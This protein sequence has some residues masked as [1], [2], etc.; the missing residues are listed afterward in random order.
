MNVFGLMNDPS[1]PEVPKRALVQ[2]K[3]SCTLLP[4]GHLPMWPSHTPQG[5]YCSKCWKWNGED[6][7]KCKRWDCGAHRG[8]LW[9]SSG[10]VPEDQEGKPQKGKGDGPTTGSKGKGTGSRRASTWACAGCGCKGNYLTRATCRNC[11]KPWE[12]D[13]PNNFWDEVRAQAS[14]PWSRR[15]GQQLLL[16]R[17]VAEDNQL[18]Q[19]MAEIQPPAAKHKKAKKEHDAAVAIL[20]ELWE[21]A[22]AMEILPATKRQEIA[23][24]DAAVAVLRRAVEAAEA[25]SSPTET[26]RSSSSSPPPTSP[27]D[28]A[29]AGHWTHKQVRST[30]AGVARTAYDQVL[31]Q[32]AVQ[33]Q[34]QQPGGTP[35]KLHTARDAW[36]QHKAAT[37]ST[38]AISGVVG[39]KPKSGM[40]AQQSTTPWP[41]GS[42]SPF[43]P[44]PDPQVHTQSPAGGTAEWPPHEK[45]PERYEPYKQPELQKEPQ[46]AEEAGKE[47]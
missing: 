9:Y 16:A 38:L 29:V 36:V 42:G 47:L 7:H 10:V 35:V 43:V 44:V 41:A 33:H 18:V 32:P 20:Q 15:S 25:E 27:A 19:Q 45:K 14:Q 26:A 6:H 28:L 5:W 24:Q 11:D 3:C 31:Q 4:L 17:R 40:M 1:L 23:D 34:M 22:E 30:L 46:E 12:K 21:D 13:P 8:C 2:L 39:A 37:S